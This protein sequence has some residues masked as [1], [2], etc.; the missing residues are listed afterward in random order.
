MSIKQ[1]IRRITKGYIYDLQEEIVEFTIPKLKQ[2][3]KDCEY[4]YPCTLNSNED[5]KGILSLMIHG[6]ELF[7]SEYDR[8]LTEAEQEIVR[9]GL[10]LFKE[11]F[12]ALWI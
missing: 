6:M 7:L 8:E 4:G 11:Y 9:V 3:S 5:W 10:D 1:W 2:F 12:G